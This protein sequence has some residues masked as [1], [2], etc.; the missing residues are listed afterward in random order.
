M[1]LFHSIFLII[2]SIYSLKFFSLWV[3]D[4]ES[5]GFMHLVNTGFHEGGHLIMIP[6]WSFLHILGGSVFQCLT[7]LIFAWIFYYRESNKFATM[8]CLWWMG[9]N[10]TDVA[11]YIADA[12]TRSLPL[13]SDM[14]PESHDWYNLL[15][16]MDMLRY[17]DAIALTSHSI[18]MAIMLGAIIWWVRIIVREYI[19]STVEKNQK[20]PF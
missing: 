19:D 14:W 5:M 17:D 8:F 11:I 3:L 20:L 18:G 15:S 6:F 4:Y 10:F 12:R 16:M 1:Y 9:Q 13:I 7:P 2:L